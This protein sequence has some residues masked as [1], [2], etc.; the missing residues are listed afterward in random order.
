MKKRY[1]IATLIGAFM[2]LGLIGLLAYSDGYT[3]QETSWYVP[4]AH[5]ARAQVLQNQALLLRA[6]H[7]MVQDGLS[8]LT[9]PILGCLALA[10]FMPSARL[11]THGAF[12]RRTT[13]TYS[14]L[15]FALFCLS[16]FDSFC[17]DTQPVL[18]LSNLAIALA[19]YV[20][21]IGLMTVV[22]VLPG[23]AMIGALVLEWSDKCKDIPE[24][25]EREEKQQFEL[26][27]VHRPVFEDAR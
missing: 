23:V 21:S 24:V 3:W 10:K 11:S 22:G 16:F 12:S 18:S 13:W 26:Q 25:I 20:L 15:C 2:G 17:G 19:V 8:F 4:Y 9:I 14:A 5:N 7:I 27:S 6:C 1:V